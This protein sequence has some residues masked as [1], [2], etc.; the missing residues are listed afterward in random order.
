MSK[1][2]IYTITFIND[3]FL[4]FEE[5][6]D[7]SQNKI[8]TGPAILQRHPSDHHESEGCLLHPWSRCECSSF[9]PVRGWEKVTLT[10]SSLFLDG[11]WTFRCFMMWHPLKRTWVKPWWPSTAHQTEWTIFQERGWLFV[12]WMLRFNRTKKWTFI[13]YQIWND[14]NGLDGFFFNQASWMVCET[15]NQ[16]IGRGCQWGLSHKEDVD[17]FE[18]HGRSIE[19]RGSD[20]PSGRAC[21]SLVRT[22]G[23]PW[24]VTLAWSFV[25]THDMEMN[26][27]MMMMMM[28]MLMMLMMMMIM[29]MIM[30]EVSFGISMQFSERFAGAWYVFV[31]FQWVQIISCISEQDR[32]LSM[33]GFQLQYII[34]RCNENRSLLWLIH[35]LRSFEIVR[36]TTRFLS[37]NIIA[38]EDVW[39]ALGD[40][41][42]SATW[43]PKKTRTNGKK[44]D[45]ASW[46]FWTFFWVLQQVQAAE[47]I[48]T[49]YD[50]TWL[51]R[52]WFSHVQWVPFRWIWHI[53]MSSMSS[54]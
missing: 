24:P 9:K 34:L 27:M 28:M 11:T 14:L 20:M 37:S 43:V 51:Q 18:S 3:V 35:V 10:K 54:R 17:A 45:N 47:G 38:C 1:M 32:F 23:K 33:Q 16:S 13:I 40:V 5:L 39:E 30:I 7:V 44:L 50:M 31:G 4:A 8:A 25:I 19:F 21:H 36:N 48:C 29:I 42:F 6:A 49:W 53:L 2:Y 22:I 12:F 46:R 52:S 41:V 15:G 26:I